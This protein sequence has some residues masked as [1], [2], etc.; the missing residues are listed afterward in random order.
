[1]SN[2]TLSAADFEE[3]LQQPFGPNVA[4]DKR[5]KRD[6]LHA[7]WYRLATHVGFE[8]PMM[9]PANGRSEIDV[10]CDEILDIVTTHQS[11]NYPIEPTLSKHIG[12]MTI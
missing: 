11:T 4:A 8:N 10:L 5:G 12:E 2:K 7:V 1:M 6:Y 3:I 9:R